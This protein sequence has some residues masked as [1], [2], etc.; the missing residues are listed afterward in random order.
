VADHDTVFKG[1]MKPQIGRVFTADSI[2]RVTLLRN[3][4]IS[5]YLNGVIVKEIGD[6]GRRIYDYPIFV[7]GRDKT[8]DEI[9]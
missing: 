5:A 4:R 1:I 9:K 2:F 7:A 8:S 3:D 6:G